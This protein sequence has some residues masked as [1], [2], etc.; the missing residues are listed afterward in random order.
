MSNKAKWRNFSKEE[1]SEIVKNSYSN[2][3][4]A[5]KLG[6]AVDGGGTMASLKKMYL[7][8]DLDTSHFKGQGW[9][10]ENY[11]YDVFTNGTKKKNGKSTANAIINLR[12]RKCECC[13]LT[14]WLQQPINL[15]VHHKDG[16]RSNNDLSNLQLLCPNC[17]SY[18]PTFSRKNSNCAIP[19]EDFVQALQ[20]SRSIRQALILLDLNPAGRNYDRAYELIERY[21]IVH[22][23]EHQNRKLS[24]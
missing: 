17:H 7:E 4:V 9:N 23:K 16:N 2:R 14:E 6:Y 11:N 18:T 24:E 13:G 19:E 1:I 15:E 5:R 21:N 10:K 22:L 8:L 20:E 3:E 12:G